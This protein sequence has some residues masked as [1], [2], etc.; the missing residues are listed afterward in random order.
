VLTETDKPKAVKKTLIE[1]WG[2]A[3]AAVAVTATALIQG[4]RPETKA[5]AL[6]AVTMSGAIICAFWKI[7]WDEK[8]DP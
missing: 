7:W 3:I 4:L 8:R 2:P 5:M 1:M 6:L